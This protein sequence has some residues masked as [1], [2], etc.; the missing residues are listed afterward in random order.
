M[1]SKWK[2][3]ANPV[4]DTMLYRVYRTRNTAEVDHSGNREYYGNYTQDKHA[5]QEAA[6]KLNAKEEE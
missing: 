5:A 6:D 2:V 3:T 4:C 1:K